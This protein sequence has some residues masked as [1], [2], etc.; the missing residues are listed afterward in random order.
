M[1]Q[2]GFTLIE[3]LISVALMAVL[4]VLCWRGLDSVVRARDTI[5]ASSDE[6]RALTVAFTQ[7]EDDLRRSWSAR[8]F[9]LP[10]PTID[11]STDTNASASDSGAPIA[12]DLVSET[13]PSPNGARLQRVVYRVRDGQL[14]RG[15][16]PWNLPNNPSATANAADLQPEPVMIWQPLI[17]RVAR[18]TMRAWIEPGPTGGT[19]PAWSDAVALLPPPGG[20][21]APTRLISGIE[22]K[23]ARIN[24]G[25]LVRQFSIRE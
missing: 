20:V 9:G 7:L 11:F 12:L 10:R 15:F 6:L 24:G 19:A 8:L 22:F 21:N 23:M 13:G 5:T 3:L 17:T 14:E 2:R 4:A 18:V 16:A 25:E 1:K